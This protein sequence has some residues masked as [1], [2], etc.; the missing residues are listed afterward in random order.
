MKISSNI[1]KKHKLATH[2]F[3][4]TS[5]LKIY[6]LIS[7]LIILLVL[8]VESSKVLYSK[9]NLNNTNKTKTFKTRFFKNQFTSS[10]LEKNLNSLSISSK[11]N[12]NN[13][14]NR[15]LFSSWAKI[16]FIEEQNS[17]IPN[18]FETNTQFYLQSKNN[19]SINLAAQ[20]SKGYLNI[21]SQEYFFTELTNNNLSVFTSRVE[22][23]KQQK[24]SV[25][26]N[27]ILPQN[28]L[29]YEGGVEDVGNFQEGYCF[30]IKYIHFSSKYMMEICCD[31]ISDKD[32]FMKNLVSLIPKK[33]TQNSN[34]TGALNEQKDS[35]LNLNESINKDNLSVN[36]VKYKI[37][38]GFANRPYPI[39]DAQFAGLAPNIGIGAVIQTPTIPNAIPQYSSGIL[40]SIPVH[41]GPS[42]AIISADLNSSTTATT[43]L[44]RVGWMPIGTWT[45]CTKPCGTGIQ[46][47]S[48]K[49]I[50]PLDCEGNNFEERLCNVQSCKHDLDTHL[51]NLQKASEGKWEYLGTWTVCSEPCGNGIQ[52]ITRK[53]L[54]P[55]CI[56]PLI[57]QRSCT[58][59]PCNSSLIQSAKL[60]DFNSYPECHPKTLKARIKSAS[61]VYYEAN[62]ILSM[63]NIQ[64]FKNKISYMTIPLSH[65]LS[66]HRS[67][68]QP[69]C[70]DVTK[71]S[72]EEITFCPE[73]KFIL[74]YI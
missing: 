11:L 30:I 33:E 35:K 70:V 17:S 12:N 31:T 2:Y 48:L 24:F 42:G 19:P 50:R 36:G 44:N 10:I 58:L 7:I 34:N 68:I 40:S 49:C 71:D 54:V 59:A 73:G 16:I 27:E 13:E 28:K 22:Q 57:V 9:N 26:I 61:G 23:Y 20:D 65:I 14:S 55:P 21:P 25:S 72:N 32:N 62:I 38:K 67:A 18:K 53:C 5:K 60:F 46:S 74:I 47:R 3:F 8:S 64:I 1:N 15:V 63:E 39:N 6:M 66:F 51:N 43:P 45:P 52:T 41:Q 69:T 56:G 37:Q 29:I 4:Q